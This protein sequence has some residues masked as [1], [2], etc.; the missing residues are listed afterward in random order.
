MIKINTNYLPFRNREQQGKHLGNEAANVKRPGKL[1]SPF[2][3]ADMAG[4]STT[5][6]QMRSRLKIYMQE[7]KDLQQQLSK[8]QDQ[9]TSLKEAQK[10]L[11]RKQGD[12]NTFAKAEGLEP[13][14]ENHFEK[15]P[16]MLL[17]LQEAQEK[18]KNQITEKLVAKENVTANLVV[19]RE[20]E[21]AEN[22]MKNVKNF[23]I[24]HD[25]LPLSNQV[26][27]QQESILDLLK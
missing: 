19:I 22:I 10:Q 5:G 20:K 4:N 23:L 13:L 11:V 3:A 2:T 6:G 8:L 9:E 12:N 16:Q 14:P 17:S 25:E 21:L 15:I 27:L 7:I 24:A 1:S 18:I 26:Q